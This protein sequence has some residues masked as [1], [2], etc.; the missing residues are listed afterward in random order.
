MPPQS[1]TVFFASLLSG[2]FRTS[3]ADDPA[4]R[5]HPPS[6]YLG[7]ES[8]QLADQAKGSRTACLMSLSG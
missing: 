2:A 6:P 3:I 1:P 8:G 5:T 4:E 7:S